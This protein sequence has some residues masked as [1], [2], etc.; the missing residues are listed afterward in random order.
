MA[1]QH[2][3]DST[4]LSIPERLQEMYRRLD[5]QQP[6]PATAQDAF[7][8]LC[9][10]LDAV[11]DEHSGVERDPNP[12]LTFDGRMYPP[13]EDFIDRDGDGGI[14][15]STKGNT[16]YAGPDGTLSI[17]SRRSGQE[18]Y[19]R[20]GIGQGPEQ[21]QQSERGREQEHGAA[22]HPA[23]LAGQGFSGP[24]SVQNTAQ[25]QDPGTQ[26]TPTVS[27]ERDHGPGS[28]PSR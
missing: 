10:T 18:V 21:V 24:P 28:E 11:E 19:R 3:P 22:Q 14:H 7:D 26:G 4:T 8:R 5:A 12:G 2:D 25:E 9:A 13:R 15:A 27:R 17:S 6:A 23:Q 20:D 16:I 1:E